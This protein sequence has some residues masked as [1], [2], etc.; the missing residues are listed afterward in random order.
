VR[1]MEPPHEG[2][3]FAHARYDTASCSLAC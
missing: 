1:G 2:L 3:A